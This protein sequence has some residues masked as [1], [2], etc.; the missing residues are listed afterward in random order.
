MSSISQMTNPRL[1]EVPST[2]GWGCAGIG[3]RSPGTPGD[4]VVGVNP[5]HALRPPSSYE[6]KTR[7]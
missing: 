6:Q 2:L 4:R 7:K 1:R 5:S 3:T